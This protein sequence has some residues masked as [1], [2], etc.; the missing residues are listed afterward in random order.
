MAATDEPALARE[1]DQQRYS[2]IPEGL[3]YQSG[4]TRN[5]VYAAFFVGFVMM[6]GAIYLGLV[7]G[8]SIAGASEWV[9]IILFIFIT[10]R[11][12]L[13]LTVQEIIIMY[14]IAAGLVVMGGKLGS[15]ANLFGGPMGGLIWDQFFVRSP[16]A[17][18][19]RDR[20]PRWVAPGPDSD[21]WAVRS[22]F[23]RDW[24]LPILVLV[25]FTALVRINNL[26]LSYILFRGASDIEKLPFPLAPVRAGGAVALAEASGQQESWRWRV[27]STGAI[28]GLLYGAIYAG[29]PIATNL[30]LTSTI[31]VVPIPFID[32]TAQLKSH[33]PATPVA[34]GTDLAAVLAGFVI[35]FEVVVG[36]FVTA[37]V[38]TL[39]GY[40]TL[41]HFGVLR[42][43]VPGMSYIPTS[44]ADSM[45]FTLSFSVG[46]ALWVALLGVIVTIR[47]MY[48]LRRQ[49]LERR[50]R[51][52]LPP[53]RGD[54]AI[55]KA[56][57][58][59]LGG[60]AGLVF[61]CWVLI[62]DE[63]PWWIPA[64]FGFGFS[65]L[66]CYINARMIG[67]TGGTGQINF[68]Y[69]R[70]GA[71]WLFGRGVAMWFAP[72][73]ISQSGAGAE[74]FKQLELTRTRF[75]SVVKMTILAFFVMW[76]GS[77]LF[78]SLIWRLDEIP[79]ST[80]PYVQ[81]MWPLHA[82]WQ[83]LW[84]KT[85]VQAQAGESFLGQILR[86]H[87]ITA[88]FSVAVALSA[89]LALLRLPLTFMYGA[90]GG[91]SANAF[92]AIPMFAGACLG[93]YY[94]RRRLGEQKWK[95]YAPILLAGY[96][97]GQGLLGMIAV[98]MAL[99]G[100]CVSPTVY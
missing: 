75:G 13:R 34:I 52:E 51:D 3:Q 93:R 11:A 90:I 79:S 95:A 88:G 46:T 68:P 48:R 80:Y 62:G 78:W 31:Q 14:W 81:R 67:I 15:G 20:I 55:W 23:H 36:G 33:L 58:I 84:I 47:Q 69:L 50:G 21:A 99:I 91:L 74:M 18:M 97:C 54:I 71:F 100:K 82:M 70:E 37:V 16:E 49:A 2:V 59:W 63:L 6:P 4:F 85:T 17:S 76:A 72:V 56:V 8:Q 22:L 42:S 9:T 44:F 65:P 64:M 86:P 73:P 28:V 1:P 26:S 19:F 98:A 96:M 38:M 10:R 5:I 12:F 92:G 7:T 45:D 87:H 83:S 57:L 39:I 60:T 61:M 25:F 40:P 32:L 29:V 94:F 41:Y 27:F 66:I 43:W 35:P 30:L 89:V 24:F 77:Y 53:G